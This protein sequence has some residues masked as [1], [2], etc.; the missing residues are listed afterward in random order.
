MTYNLDKHLLDFK[1]EGRGPFPFDMLR[2]D[3]AWPAGS[4]DS[5]QMM[6]DVY[7]RRIVKL[8]MFK[9]SSFPRPTTGRWASFG[10]VVLP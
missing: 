2:Y 1:V 4:D 3:Q 5:A 9:R 10:W 6:P 8:T 7:E